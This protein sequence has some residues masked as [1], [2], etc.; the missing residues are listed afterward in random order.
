[1]AARL[2]KSADPARATGAPAEDVSARVADATSTH[3]RATARRQAASRLRKLTYSCSFQTARYIC[4]GLVTLSQL[5][6]SW[7][8]VNRHPLLRS[9]CLRARPVHV[10][11]RARRAGH[12]A[13]CQLVRGAIAVEGR[14]RRTNRHA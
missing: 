4:C 7:E 9:R 8:N 3:T 11:R 14:H 1:M 12:H 5:D 13:L 10:G 2:I 6:W